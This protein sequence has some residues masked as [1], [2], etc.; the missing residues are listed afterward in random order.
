[1]IEDTRLAGIKG[2]QRIR[3]LYLCTEGI[4][5]VVINEG[6]ALLKSQGQDEALSSY[7]N[8]H[9]SLFT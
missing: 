4:Y 6:V 3:R 9:A 5:G 7:P 8:L 2:G 1:M